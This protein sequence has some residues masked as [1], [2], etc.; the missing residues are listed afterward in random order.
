[1]ALTLD[2][3]ISVWVEH[4]WN[5]FSFLMSQ[6]LVSCVLNRCLVF[7]NYLS[8]KRPIYKCP[9]WDMIFISFWKI[10]CCFNLKYVYTAYWKRPITFVHCLTRKITYKLWRF[11]DNNVPN[12]LSVL[13]L[14]TTTI[15]M[16][17]KRALY[18]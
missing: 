3:L 12:D 7:F 13:I 17:A 4:K 11:S 8:L 6:F 2:I 9:Q 14:L 15:T 16:R 1:M 5:F 10:D 18:G